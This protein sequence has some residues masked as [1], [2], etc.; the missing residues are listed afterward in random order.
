MP[1]LRIIYCIGLT[2]ATSISDIEEM[3]ELE[4][5]TEPEWPCRNENFR[6]MDCLRWSSS[7]FTFTIAFFFA[8]CF[9]FTL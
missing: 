7:F 9:F 1:P 5:N 8:S 4:S 2:Y 6:L 3:L